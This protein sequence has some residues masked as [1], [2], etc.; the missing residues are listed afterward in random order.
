MHSL[1]RDT[2]CLAM[3]GNAGLLSQ[4]TSNTSEH[5]DALRAYCYP[6]EAIS[7]RTPWDTRLLLMAILVYLWLGEPQ[8]EPPRQV[9]SWPD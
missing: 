5:K 1:S 6:R 3:N 9:R 8:G 4:M 2:N 7:N